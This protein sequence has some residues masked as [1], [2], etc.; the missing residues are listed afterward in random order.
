MDAKR[1]KDGVTV[2]LKTV[3]QT[4]KEAKIAKYF[5]SPEL[6]REPTNHSVP[7]LEVF[8]DPSTPDFEY[9]VMPLLR[10]FDDPE[11]TMIGEVVDFI[12]QIL[13]GLTFMHSHNIAHG[14]VDFRDGSTSSVA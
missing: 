4:P 11:F 12:T 3:Y 14:L 8:L 1:L 7:I 9:L 10:P 6:L 2:C 13:E 5:S